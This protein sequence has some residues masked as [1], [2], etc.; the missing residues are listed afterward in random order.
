MDAQF[1]APPGDVAEQRRRGEVIWYD[2][3]TLSHPVLTPSSE[4]REIEGKLRSLPEEPGLPW[5]IDHVKHDEN[6]FGFLEDVR[7]TIFRYQVCSQNATLSGD[8][9][10]HSRWS[11]KREL[12]TGH[13]NP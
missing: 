4:L 3:V 12:T 9:N 7:E 1:V 10:K 8:V 11:G 2:M 6:V 13:S 5:V